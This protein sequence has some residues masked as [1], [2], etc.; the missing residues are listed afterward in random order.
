MH[1]S[2]SIFISCSLDE[3]RSILNFQVDA[4]CAFAKVAK[5]RTPI[6]MKNANRKFM[7]DTSSKNGAKIAKIAKL[8]TR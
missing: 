3:R 1:T 2:D 6:G 8:R 7:G 4:T 5:I